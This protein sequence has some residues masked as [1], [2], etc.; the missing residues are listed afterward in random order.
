MKM[1]NEYRISDDRLRCVWRHSVA[2]VKRIVAIVGISL[3]LLSCAAGAEGAGDI[4][5]GLAYDGQTAYLLQNGEVW[6]LDGDLKPQRRLDVQGRTVRN[7]CADDGTLYL[8]CA[9]PEGIGFAAWTAAGI[10]EL[11]SVPGEVD[12]D[13][14]LVLG[15]EMIV[16]WCGRAEDRGRVPVEDDRV[17]AFSLS[18]EKRRFPVPFA[19]RLW[20]GGEGQALLFTGSLGVITAVDVADGTGVELEPPPGAIGDM[21]GGP[22][23]LYCL[24]A[25][26]LYAIRDDSAS[27][28]CPGDFGGACEL[29]QLGDR[30]VVFDKWPKQ[31]GDAIRC[32]YDP[33]PS[34]KRQGLT[35]VGYGDAPMNL[36]PRMLRAQALWQADFPD[37]ALK[38]V[39]L[40]MAQLNT[41]LMAGGEGADLICVS[42]YM[43]EPLIASGALLDLSGCP[44]IMDALAEW[45]PGA[46]MV[47]YRGQV[48][49]APDELTLTAL[50]EQRALAGRAPA[51]F[52][53]RNC[54]WQEFLAAALRFSGDLNGDGR[55]EAFFYTE[56]INQ[57][58]WLKQYVSR[59]ADLSQVA[60]DTP[61]FRELLSLYRAAVHADRIVD[62]LDERQTGDNVL[63]RTELYHEPTAH[64]WQAEPL[65]PQP[66]IGEEACPVARQTAFAVN[67]RSPHREAALRL[68]ECFLSADAAYGDDGGTFLRTDSAERMG[69]AAYAGA[70]RE[71]LESETA[72]FAALRPDCSTVEFRIV[73]GELLD[74]YY[75]GQIDEEE[76]IRALERELEKR[77]MG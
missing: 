30:I 11:F 71:R 57:P 4:Q 32:A 75:A 43:N 56:Q 70:A 65:I 29:C 40:P 76:L 42:L 17:G 12:V 45:I 44:E 39:Q 20:R 53:V 14:F 64:D 2:P 61:Q 62:A 25:D 10:E 16:L 35:I 52:D 21:A 74:R 51:D 46:V 15:D 24:Y 48:F 66:R 33:T 5:N 60:F 69:A 49:G 34:A 68:L 23:A 72:C 18:G 13:E 55:A 58:L 9:E 47:R 7:I 3:L 31:P 26:G 67:V 54:S 36:S 63:Y 50:T 27:N 6:Q 41:L 8:A 19:V 59:W 28:L 38:F 77:R 22:D 1:W 37:M 73:S